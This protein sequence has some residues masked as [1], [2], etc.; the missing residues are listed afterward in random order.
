MND[1]SGPFPLS[2]HCNP[3]NNFWCISLC[4]CGLLPI[5]INPPCKSLMKAIYLLHRDAPTQNQQILSIYQLAVKLLPFCSGA[6]VSIAHL[7]ENKIPPSTYLSLFR[8]NYCDKSS[9]I[10][11]PIT[12][13]NDIDQHTVGTDPAL[14]ERKGLADDLQRFFTHHFLSLYESW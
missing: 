4:C 7:P 5:L 10:S 9:N 13:Y 14:A 3:I 12:S 8:F 1:N 6:S 11:F 2:S